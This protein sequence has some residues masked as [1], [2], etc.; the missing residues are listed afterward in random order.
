MTSVYP[1]KLGG[2][3]AYSCILGGQEVLTVINT[4]AN[5]GWTVDVIVS[6]QLLIEN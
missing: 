6:P 4:S 1:G 2:V 5:K 3:L